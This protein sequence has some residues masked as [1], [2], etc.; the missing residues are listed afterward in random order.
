VGAEQHWEETMRIRGNNSRNTLTGTS[1][2]DIIFGLGGRDTIFA[3]SGNDFIVGGH[4]PDRIDGGDDVD[5]ASYEDSLMG[6]VVDLVTGRGIGGDAEGDRLFNIENL[7]GSRHDDF[8]NGNDQAN[9][10]V[11]GGGLDFLDGRGGDDHLFGGSGDDIL[12]GGAGADEIVGGP[13]TDTVTYGDSPVVV[14]LGGYNGVVV[15]LQ[16]GLGYSGDADGDTLASIENVAG[17]DHDDFLIGND[18]ANRLVGL[19]GN[20][21]LYG[22][23]G[24]DYLFGDNPAADPMLGGRG[25][26]ILSG[27]R[28]ADHLFG[29]PGEDVLIGGAGADHLDGGSGADTAAYTES[30]EGVLVNLAAGVGFSGTAQG[31]VLVDIENLWGSRHDD[32]LVGDDEANY[33]EGGFGDDQLVGGG[34]GDVLFGGAQPRDGV[35]IIEPPGDGVP[36]TDGHDTL[37]GGRGRDQ[38]IGGTGADTLTGGRDADIFIWRT[39]TETGVLVVDMDLITDFNRREGDLIDVHEIDADETIFGN[40]DFTFVG[41]AGFSAPGQIRYATV[42][43]ETWIILNTDADTAGEVAIRVAGVHTVDA[44][45]FSP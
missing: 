8:L 29:G 15:S 16:E 18:G 25:D 26:D 10:L 11:G 45:W 39:V 1:D 20:D 32:V 27:G 34:G 22:A 36:L 44:S 38:L 14:P 24:D 37:V 40:Q 35:D 19:A 31:D 2:D 6:V 30:D 7:V 28:G 33:I 12:H 3:G 43:T 5:T 21:K 13:G 9:V 42:G 41:T 23:A 17:S 4:D